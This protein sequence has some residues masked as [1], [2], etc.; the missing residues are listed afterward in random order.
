MAMGGPAALATSTTAT[1]PAHD[2]AACREHPTLLSSP[3]DGVNS[4][5]QSLSSPLHGPPLP[6]SR[7]SADA[8]GDDLS[9]TGNTVGSLPSA[10]TPTQCSAAPLRSRQ[11][12]LNAQSLSFTIALERPSFTDWYATAAWDD[13]STGSCPSSSSW[14]LLNQPQPRNAA[15]AMASSPISPVD[16]VATTLFI[17][18]LPALIENKWQLQP[19]VPPQGLVALRVKSSRG[20]NVGFAVYDSIAAAREALTWFKQMLIIKEVVQTS[21]LGAPPAAE[22]ARGTEAPPV[23]ACGGRSAPPVGG[24]SDCFPGS[25]VELE[26]MPL[27]Y[28]E[29]LCTQPV[30][31]Q[32]ASLLRRC[33]LLRAEWARS[34]ETQHPPASVGAAAAAA[35]SSVASSPLSYPPSPWGT[36]AAVVRPPQ[37]PPTA[38]AVPHVG[39]KLSHDGGDGYSQMS[40]PARQAP[41][42]QAPLHPLPSPIA[43]S[44]G[45]QSPQQ[46]LNPCAAVS[47]ADAQAAH[48]PA[49][50]PLFLSAP[51]HAPSPVTRRVWASSAPSVPLHR[52]EMRCYHGCGAAQKV[53]H[54]HAHS[55]TCQ[56]PFPVHRGLYM[57]E[58]SDARE[59]VDAWRGAPPEPPASLHR[60]GRPHPRQH[61]ASYHYHQHSS[62]PPLPSRTLFVRL[63][64]NFDA[65]GYLQ[66][67]QVRSSTGSSTGSASAMHVKPFTTA[68][69]PPTIA[70]SVTAPGTTTAYAEEAALP[71]PT[72]L[73]AQTT[74]SLQV[75]PTSGAA[76]TCPLISVVP[77]H[78]HHM[79]YQ[80]PSSPTLTTTPQLRSPLDNG[81]TQM[82][83]SWQPPPSSQLTGP[84]A[85]RHGGG[86]GAANE[87]L[88]RWTPNAEDREFFR[89]AQ[90]V[91]REEYFS[92]KF[93]GFLRYREFLRPPYY[94]GCFVLFERGEDMQRCLQWMRKDERLMKLFAVAPARNDSFGP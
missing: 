49:R 70:G 26:P 32:F 29:Y 16:T 87:A 24:R 51:H 36:A 58:R 12:L 73:V 65:P 22:S 27:E 3:F 67:D 82:Y 44:P 47:C 75:S 54:Q 20:R 34:L 14:S 69:L 17:D 85:D 66:Q 90:S 37:Q 15:R 68:R 77:H 84:C 61:H 88:S 94:G 56:P 63:I 1:T 92:E 52:S 35:A 80:S 43:W 81:G 60:Q 71:T 28:E 7:H 59:R 13:P 57:A 8:G 72:R 10:S 53:C 31:G 74:P 50:N 93:A 33:A 41:T 83:S 42:L 91:L 11:A 78:Y 30:P 55:T 19:Y 5:H 9:P 64:H 23:L 39:R 86:A 6:R 48:P 4:Q 62:E 46:P 89:F 76:G 38:T 21:T 25:P 18:G 2:F 45:S 40:E 79:C